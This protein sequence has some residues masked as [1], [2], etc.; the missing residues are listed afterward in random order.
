MKYFTNIMRLPTRSRKY[1]PYK[2]PKLSELLEYL[3][4][5]TYKVDSYCERL[6]KCNS[7]DLH[8]SRFDTT[9]LYVASNVYKERLQGGTEWNTTFCG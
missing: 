9:A 5:S 3:N 7:I 2:S 1:G 8:D 4:I 6:F